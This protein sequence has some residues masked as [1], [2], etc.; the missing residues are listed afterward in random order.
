MWRQDTGRAAARKVWGGEDLERRSTTARLRRGGGRSLGLAGARHV[1][2]ASPRRGRCDR[3]GGGA[4]TA[5]L[6]QRPPPAGRA[7]APDGCAGAAAADAPPGRKRRPSEREGERRPSAG[8]RSRRGA[9][10]RKAKPAQ[11][12]EPKGEAG[13]DAQRRKAKPQPGRYRTPKCPRDGQIPNTC[14]YRVQLAIGRDG[15]LDQWPIS[16]GIRDESGFGDR[17]AAWLSDFVRVTRRVRGRT[18][19]AARRTGP[20]PRQQ[21]THPAG[22]ASPQARPRSRRGLPAG[23]TSPQARPPA[24]LRRAGAAVSPPSRS[25]R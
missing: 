22:A 11:R 4:A 8:G 12:P 18:G 24:R 1:R 20:P 14:G 6:D 3:H 16:F 21:P 13:A 9:Q 5:G 25:G 19:C 2:A 10:S 7:F 17:E 15:P 23:A